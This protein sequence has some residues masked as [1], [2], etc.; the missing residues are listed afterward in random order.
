MKEQTFRADGSDF[1]FLIGQTIVKT[2]E[3]EDGY[4]LSTANGQ[5]VRVVENEGC[6]GCSDGWSEFSDILLLEN[7]DNA[8]MNVVCESGDNSYDDSFKLFIYYHDKTLEITG[9]DGYG[10]GYYGGG[11]W[12]TIKNVE[13]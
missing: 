10:N 3:T 7:A 1:D 2:R 6:G 8:I 9:D 11:F 13:G 12:V 4:E 5:I